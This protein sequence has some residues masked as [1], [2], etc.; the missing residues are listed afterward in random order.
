MLI[1]FGFLV[2][3]KF[4]CFRS[5]GLE[6]E[7]DSVGTFLGAFTYS[8]SG[9]PIQTFKVEVRRHLE[10]FTELLLT[11]FR[12]MFLCF[13]FNYLQLFVCFRGFSKSLNSWVSM[14]RLRGLLISLWACLPSSCLFLQNSTAASYRFIELKINSNHGNDHYTCLYRFRVH[15]NVDPTD[16]GSA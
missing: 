11:L 14:E 6:N 13:L 5:K 8:S 9:R 16:P 1:A 10:M 2:I 7:L 15:G 12:V 4:R 3:E